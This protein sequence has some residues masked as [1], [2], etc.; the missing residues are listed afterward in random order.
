MRRITA[1]DQTRRPVKK[2]V[3]TMARMA[4]PMMGWPKKTLWSADPCVE[5]SVEFEAMVSQP[6]ITVL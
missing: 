3:N 6:L 4:T 1:L 2:V 5:L